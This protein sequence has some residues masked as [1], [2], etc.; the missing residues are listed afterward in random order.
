MLSASYSG[1][2]LRFDDSLGLAAHAGRR[3]A[4]LVGTVVV[5]RAAA[6]HG[7]DGVA[8]RD[9]VSEPLRTTTA[10]PLPLTVPLAAASKARHFPSGDRMPAGS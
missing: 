5:D 1:D 6:N 2:I 8:M 10:P 7:I 4:G 9:R 3:I